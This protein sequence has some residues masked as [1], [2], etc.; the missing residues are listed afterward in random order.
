MNFR[1]MI[2]FI[3]VENSILG[4]NIIHKHTGFYKKGLFDSIFFVIVFLGFYPILQSFGLIFVKKTR[5][6]LD[7]ISKLDFV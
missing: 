1:S 4:L 6:A 7:G 5:D 3:L 2:F